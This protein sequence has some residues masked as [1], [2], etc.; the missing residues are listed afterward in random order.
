MAQ[1]PVCGMSVNEDTARFS[2]EYEGKKY[3]FCYKHCKMQFDM[4][5][6]KYLK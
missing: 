3:Y 1:D 6:K 2:S 4:D 5:P